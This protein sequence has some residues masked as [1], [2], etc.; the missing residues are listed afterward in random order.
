MPTPLE[1][2]V[3]LIREGKVEEARPLLIA[4]LKQNPRDENAWL[5]MTRCVTEPEQK[6]YCFEKVLKIN[7]QNQYAIKGLQHIDNLPPSTSQPK[8]KAVQYIAPK[9]KRQ[10]KGLGAIA[11]IGLSV[12]AISIICMCAIVLINSNPTNSTSNP[13]PTQRVRTNYR[14]MLESNGFTYFMSDN[15]GNP[16]YSSPCGAVALVKPDSVGFVVSHSSENNCATED[17]GRIIDVMYPSEV[18]DCVITTMNLLDG[19]DQMLTREAVGYKVTAAI[20]E[21]EHTL[22]VVIYDP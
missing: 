12:A 7:P 22:V 1:Q 4:Y 16:S 17:I 8:P 9:A 2:A 10:S 20:T 13:I 21:Y 11:I 5:W 15:E 3:S 19:F 6:K 18:F 14:Q